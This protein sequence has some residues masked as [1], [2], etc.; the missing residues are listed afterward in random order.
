MSKQNLTEGVFDLIL[1]YQFVKRL[2]TPFVEQEAYKLGIID[3]KGNRIK[4]KKLETKEEK[5]AYGYLDRLIFNL[6]KLIEKVPGGRSRLGS[7]AAALFLIREGNSNKD[8]TMDDLQEG[9]E[10]TMRELKSMSKKNFKELVEEVPAN[11]T[12]S[13]VAGTGDDSDTVV[14]KKKKR[15][16]EQLKVDFRKKQFKEFLR[17]Y[18]NGKSKRDGLKELKKRKEILAR[19]GL[20]R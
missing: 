19:F 17:N 6:K 15:E 7:F 20:D 5:K 1:I 16:D 14:V 9:L 12:G 2:S 13:A 4:S 18:L 11:A 10:T 3:D 8:Y